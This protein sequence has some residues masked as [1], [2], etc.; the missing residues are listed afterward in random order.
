VSRLR[1]WFLVMA[2]LASSMNIMAANAAGVWRGQITVN[3]EHRDVTLSLRINGSGLT[4]TMTAEGYSDTAELLD[5]SVDGDDVSFFIESGADDVPRF[6]F[7]GTI[8]GDELKLTIYG[9]VKTTGANL[10]LGD[11][12]LTRSK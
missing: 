3:A 1:L 9:R 4:G 12:A 11:G 5:G 6:E 8:T 10:T 7:H 2:V